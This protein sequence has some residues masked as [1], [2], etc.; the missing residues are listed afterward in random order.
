MQ[1]KQVFQQ[2][3]FTTIDLNKFVPDTHPLKRIE[4]VLDLSY[5]RALTKPYYSENIGRAS[6][7]PVVFSSSVHDYA[8]RKSMTMQSTLLSVGTLMLELFT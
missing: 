1:G 6:L 8:Y 2:P 7:D 4:K 3:L 5:I